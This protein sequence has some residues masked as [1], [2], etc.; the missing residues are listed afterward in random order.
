MQTG[1]I[2]KRLIGAEELVMKLKITAMDDKYIH[3]GPWKFDRATGA[4]IDEDLGWNA[5]QT[6]SRLDLS[7]TK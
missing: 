1:D 3:C 4:E 6:G 2:V 7:D 5:T